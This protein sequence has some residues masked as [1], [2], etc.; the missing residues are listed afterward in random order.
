M[1]YLTLANQN[2]EDMSKKEA[3]NK[4]I[5][6]EKKQRKY[7]KTYD[8]TNQLFLAAGNEKQARVCKVHRK[9]KLQRTIVCR[10]YR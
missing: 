4:K 5:D 7:Q 6:W 8:T 10:S 9:K 2:L 1:K 3:E